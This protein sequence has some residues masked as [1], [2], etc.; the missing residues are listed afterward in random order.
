LKGIHV[1]LF[2]FA[3]IAQVNCSGSVT[4]FHIGKLLSQAAIA[5]AGFTTLARRLYPLLSW[6]TRI[7]TAFSSLLCHFRGSN[8]PVQTFV[9]FKLSV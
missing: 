6:H 4:G 9:D 8:S 1:V 3:R 2:I 7:V 5:T